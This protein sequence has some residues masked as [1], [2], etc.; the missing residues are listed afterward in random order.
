MSCIPVLAFAPSRS[1]PSLDRE[2][3]TEERVLHKLTP[4]SKCV[5]GKSMCRFGFAGLAS[6][7]GIAA[8]IAAVGECGDTGGTPAAAPA[9]FASDVGRT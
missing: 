5:A 2:R 6:A 9:P 1:A 8:G 3:E 4:R 7:A